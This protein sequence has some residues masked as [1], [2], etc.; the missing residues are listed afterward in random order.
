MGMIYGDAYSGYQANILA[1]VGPGDLFTRQK[2]TE[3]KMKLR[4]GGETDPEKPPE[5][6]EGDQYIVIGA[7]AGLVVGGTVGAVIGGYCFGLGGGI[8]GALVGIIG[9][10]ILGTQTGK[11][12]KNRRQ[13][14]KTGKPKLT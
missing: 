12:M 8:T 11:R 2:E 5:P 7:I 1:A 10:G 4:Y 3:M 13:E 9:G 14:A 6:E